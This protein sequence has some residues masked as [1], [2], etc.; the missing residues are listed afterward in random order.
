MLRNAFKKARGLWGRA[1]SVTT[2]LLVYVVCNGLLVV[3]G[4]IMTILGGS[5][6][7]AVGTSLIAT[8]MAGGVLFLYIL[9]TERLSERYEL[10]SE[11]GLLNIFRSRSVSIRAEYESRLDNARTHIDLLGFGQRAFREDF[12]KRFSAWAN[13][14]ASV[15][16]LLL[17]PNYP[18]DAWQLATQRDSEEGNTEGDIGRDVEAFLRDTQSLRAQV[19][20]FQV[21]LYGCL[22]ALNILRIDDELFWGPYLIRK[23][24]RNA[25]TLLVSRG[26]LYDAMVDHFESI[27][28]DATL[29]IAAD[30]WHRR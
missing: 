14:G 30:D 6:A 17:D 9:M 25:P 10:I 21:R 27:W 15:R 23:P 1:T 3:I 18:N 12:G 4:L 8:G 16:I 20:K 5:L 22:P 26:E 11:F 24:S 7:A 29:S 13:N 28:N 2:R 19:D